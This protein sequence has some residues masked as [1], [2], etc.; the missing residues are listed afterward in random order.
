MVEY[1]RVFSQVGFLWSFAQKEGAKMSETRIKLA[2][3]T[4]AYADGEKNKL[5]PVPINLPH[6]KLRVPGAFL[7]FFLL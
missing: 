2:P 5:W 3:D 6:R 1:L 4:V 7:G